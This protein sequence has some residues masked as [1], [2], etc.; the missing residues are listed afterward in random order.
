MFSF[1]D[2]LLYDFWCPG[3]ICYY[4]KSQMQDSSEQCSPCI[5]HFRKDTRSTEGL[6]WDAGYINTEPE[7]SRLKPQSWFY[8]TTFQDPLLFPSLVELK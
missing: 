3:M 8:L 6:V 1:I 4:V 2:V 5:K 7:Y